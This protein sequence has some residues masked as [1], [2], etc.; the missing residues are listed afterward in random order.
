MPDGLH[1]P[2]GQLQKYH[3]GHDLQCRRT[4]PQ[5]WTGIL[6]SGK[7]GGNG[8]GAT[9]KLY[10][11]IPGPTGP[12]SSFCGSGKGRYGSHSLEISSSAAGTHRGHRHPAELSSGTGSPSAGKMPGQGRCPAAAAACS[13]GG[14]RP[15]GQFFA[16][17]QPE[18]GKCQP[19]AGR[20]MCRV[21]KAAAFFVRRR[22]YFY[23]EQMCENVQFSRKNGKTAKEK[24]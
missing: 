9:A 15:F 24:D 22:Q 21:L 12:D 19:P 23:I 5:R 17:V 16:A 18:T 6:R 8:G 3:C 2:Q 13:D 7:A 11:G 10:S 1:R 20:W 14:G 4:A